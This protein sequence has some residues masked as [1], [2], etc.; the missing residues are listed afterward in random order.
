MNRGVERSGSADH[1]DVLAVLALPVLLPLAYLE[2]WN[3][4]AV[5]VD[6]YD[7]IEEDPKDDK[8]TEGES[9]VKVALLETSAEVRM[10]CAL[11]IKI[12]ED[13]G[14]HDILFL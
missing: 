5:V 2:N 11:L 13:C 8:A 1:E 3:L 9:A 7:L 6:E 12:L 14:S 10:V 4:V